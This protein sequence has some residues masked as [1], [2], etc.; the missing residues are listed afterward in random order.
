MNCPWRVAAAVALAVLCFGLSS[1]SAQKPEKKHRIF[2]EGRPVPPTLELLWLGSDAV[3]RGVVETQQVFSGVPSTDA[4]Q[5]PPTMRFGV[6]LTEVFKN[7]GHIDDKSGVLQVLA[8]GA[9]M[10]RG[11]HYDVYEDSRFPLPRKGQDLILFLTWSTSDA[12][13]S[14]TTLSGDSIYQ[15]ANKSLTSNGRTQL[16]RGLVALAPDALLA[17]LRA[18]GGAR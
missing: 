16:A 8:P 13:F 14:A 2:T 7:D 18:L 15:L 6:R 9:I 4:A 3:V 5:R 11:P 10:D 17:R 1:I 12:G